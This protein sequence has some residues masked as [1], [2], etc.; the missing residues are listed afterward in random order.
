MTITLLA[1]DDSRTIQKVLEMTFA[2]DAYRLLLAND[3]LDALDKLN[4]ERPSVVL[5]DVGAGSQGGYDLAHDIKAQSPGTSVLLMSS[6]HAPFDAARGSTADGNIDK[7]FDS[8][9][10]LDAVTKLAAEATID[11]TTATTSPAFKAVTSPRMSP[12]PNASEPDPAPVSLVQPTAKFEEKTPHP[13]ATPRAVMGGAPAA[14]FTEKLGGLG[15][16]AAQVEGVLALSREVVEQVVWEVV[17]T[18]AEALIK[19][20][21]RRLTSD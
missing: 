15:L 19:E 2:E 14:T 20:E 5:I 21:I 1:V 9:K 10:M 4:R 16:T 17:P 11:R 13:P 3:A 6:Q 8:Q 12:I 7:P 18:L